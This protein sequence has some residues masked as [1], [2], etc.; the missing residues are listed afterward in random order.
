MTGKFTNT[1][2]EFHILQSFPVSCLNRDDGGAPKSAIIGGVERARVSSQCW[3]RAVRLALQAE[4]VAIAAR[5]K[6]V[7]AKI[8]EQCEGK[9]AS[10]EQAQQCGEAAAKAL[11]KTVKDGASDTLFFISNSEAAEVAAA[12]AANDF[13]PLG[14]KELVKLLKQHV[15]SALDGLDIALFGRMVANVPELNMEAAA[16]FAHA[17]ST[18]KATSEV[19]FFTAVDDCNCE[20]SGAGH[21]GSLEFNSAT[22][23]RYVSLDLGQLAANLHSGELDTAVEAFVKALFKAFPAARQAT[24][25]AACPWNYAI[26]TVRNGQGMQLPFNAPVRPQH[27]EDMVSAS[28]RALQQRFAEVER[29]YGSLFGLRA[30]FEI[31]TQSGDID[32]LLSALKQTIQAI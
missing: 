32:S 27:G 23:Y 25:A 8:A 20:D 3:K 4:G 29:M 11:T 21:M 15:N 6:L 22:Y 5:T 26:V 28:I 13:S 24:M 18:H 30:K 17:I 16:S 19:D 10:P 1:R 9:G 12:C 31:G 2:I 14:E 7:A